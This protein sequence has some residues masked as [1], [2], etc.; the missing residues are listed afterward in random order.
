MREQESVRESK[1]ASDEELLR[2]QESFAPIM[3]ISSIDQKINFA[4]VADRSM[5]DDQIG[6]SFKIDQ[7]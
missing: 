7:P 4:P 3:A 1:R 2:E 5:S 6:D